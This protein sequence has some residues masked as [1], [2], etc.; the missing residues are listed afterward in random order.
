MLI[1]N[2][3]MLFIFHGC[4][5]AVH[6]YSSLCLLS[7]W[8]VLVQWLL[9]WFNRYRI[10][11]LQCEESSGARCWWWV[12]NNMNAFNAAEPHTSRCL[13]SEFHWN[14]LKQWIMYILPQFKINLRNCTIMVIVALFFL[15]ILRKYCLGSMLSFVPLWVE[16]TNLIMRVSLFW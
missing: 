12:R 9:L 2:S 14:S 8:G 16:N 1:Y 7:Q 13:N 5:H 4:N 3:S 11:L 6:E 15:L 10:S